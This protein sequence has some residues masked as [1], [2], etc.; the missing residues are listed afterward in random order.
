MGGFGMSIDRSGTTIGDSGTVTSAPALTYGQW[1]H[2]SVVQDACAGT[3]AWY[4]DGHLVATN[5]SPST[6]P[7]LGSLILG[8]TSGTSPTDTQFYWGDVS[9]QVASCGA[10]PS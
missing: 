4:L 8:E 7:Q 6:S 5:N 9:L 2:V 10:P 1:H 3:H